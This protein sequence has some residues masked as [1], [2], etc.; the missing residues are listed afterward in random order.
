MLE[1]ADYHRGITLAWEWL[2][3]GP[4]AAL[5]LAEASSWSGEEGAREEGVTT[6]FRRATDTVKPVSSFLLW[7]VRPRR[8]GTS[9]WL[10]VLE[11]WPMPGKLFCGN[12]FVCHLEEEKLP[13]RTLGLWKGMEAG[14]HTFSSSTCCAWRM[15]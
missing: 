6:G 1:H 14:S 13:G 7:N 12:C 4:E 5:P 8:A 2:C 9:R 11:L 3:K 10:V 15:G